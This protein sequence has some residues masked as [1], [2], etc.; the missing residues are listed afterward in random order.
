MSNHKEQPKGNRTHTPHARVTTSLRLALGVAIAAL[1]ISIAPAQA[2]TFNVIHNFTGR[3]DGASPFTGLTVDSGGNLYGT[4]Y[5]GGNGH[6]G[7]VF[8]L[9]GSGSDWTLTP[10]YNF[11]GGNDGAGPISQPV[12]GPDGA[13]YGSTSA[14]GGGACLNSNGYRGCGTIYKLRPPARAPGSV[15]VNWSSNAIYS[16]T[17]TN[18]AYPQGP[19][20]FSPDG[21]IFGTTING[22]ANGYGLVYSLTNSGG[23]WN[24]SVLYQGSQNGGQY[25][26]GGLIAD[27][28]GN[29]YGTF[30]QGSSHQYGAVFKLSPNGSGWT[31]STLHAFSF[32]GT[33]GANPQS[34]LVFDR[35]GNMYGTT[36]HSNGGGGTVFEMT[37][38]GGSWTYDYLYGFTGGINIGPYDK[39][40]MDSAGNLYG[41]T[42]ADGRY[43][44]GSVFKLTRS[45]DSWTYTSLHDF[46]GGSDG[47]NPMCSL[48][49]DGDG[50]IYGTASDGGT[51]NLGVVFEITP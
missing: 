30:S 11:Q 37:S 46:T 44:L 19:L 4:S 22:G 10:L 29:Y 25:P 43:G 6:Y 39:L 12:F 47:G 40:V 28:S 18:G 31:Q 49:F 33:D 3:Q 23:A 21:K 1:L 45:G 5:A 15:I 26:W 17:G 51:Y 14:G 35:S 38:S 7:T 20:L 41:T 8:T 48:V 27:A 16:F 50:N 42:F 2:Q 24:E 13:L 36:V 34:A 9:N 32:H